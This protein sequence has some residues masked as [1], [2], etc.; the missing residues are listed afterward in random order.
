MAAVFAYIV[1]A[2][3]IWMHPTN[4]IT[5]DTSW[6][7]PEWGTP[8][9]GAADSFPGR[10]GY[11]HIRIRR[12]SWEVVSEDLRRW[13]MIH[14]VGHCLGLWNPADYHDG[15]GYMTGYDYM[16]AADQFRIDALHPSPIVRRAV[17]P[18]VSH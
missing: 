13:L 4:S 3:A 10:D 18:M 17:V 6:I 16:T 14:E 9:G 5:A 15:D 2:L 1:I 11:C 7:A 8:A 12:D